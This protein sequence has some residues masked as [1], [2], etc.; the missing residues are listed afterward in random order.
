MIKTDSRGAILVVGRRDA[1]TA[2]VQANRQVLVDRQ[3]E[4]GSQ[5]MKHTARRNF[6]KE[7]C[8]PKGLRDFAQVNRRQRL[9]PFCIQFRGA[10]RNEYERRFASAHHLQAVGVVLLHVAWI[11]VQTTRPGPGGCCS[12]GGKGLLLQ[13]EC[14]NLLQEQD[15][16]GRFR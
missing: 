8:A 5:A 4:S 15:Q 1:N 2:V 10:T 11:A 9:V 16:I 3:H 13:A 7:R 12:R 6:V 14:V